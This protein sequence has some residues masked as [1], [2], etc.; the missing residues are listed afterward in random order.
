ME[1]ISQLEGYI[2]PPRT[3]MVP[4]LSLV[5]RILT[6]KKHPGL[7][8][9]KSKLYMTNEEFKNEFGKQ[10]FIIGRGTYA[11]IH[12][13]EKNF[14]I[15]EFTPDD[16]D[17]GTNFRSLTEISILKYLDH[18]NVLP[19]YG[20]NL[21]IEKCNFKF[22]MPLAQ[23]SLRDE[24]IK[25]NNTFNEYQRKLI[26]YQI[27]RGLSYCH[28][29]FIWHLDI[30]PAN[31]LK[32]SNGEYKLADF[33]IS[34]IYAF[35]GNPHE[36][37]IMS[38]PYRPPEI[39]IDDQYY[40]ETVDVWST[41]A[42]LIELITGKMFFRANTDKDMML[43]IMSLLGTPDFNNSWPEFEKLNY[44]FDLINQLPKNN[45]DTFSETL[46]DFNV[47]R[48]EMSILQQMLAWPNKRKKAIDLLNH[49]YF[50]DVRGLIDQKIPSQPIIQ[51]DCGRQMLQ[52][53]VKIKKPTSHSIGRNG[54]LMIVDWIWAVGNELKVKA[55]T[56]FF[57]YLLYDRYSS[58]VDSIPRGNEQLIILASFLLA[59]KI[60]E[61]SFSAVSDLSFLSDG[62]YTSE[63][64][65][66]MEITMLITL[67]FNIIF[68]TCADFSN[69]MMS[70]T[71][72][73]T[74][75][76]LMHNLMAV[77]M[78]NSNWAFEMD[79]REIAQSGIEI[80][81]ELYQLSE[82]ECFQQLKSGRSLSLEEI[83]EYLN[84][85]TKHDLISRV[86][87]DIKKVL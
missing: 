63:Q 58:L 27:L 25:P 80:V 73:E 86:L 1:G 10:L 44:K 6:A 55:R 84:D 35:N 15:K 34:Q 43:K 24:M 33:G 28:S 9:K 69:Y 26:I 22:A 82:T 16:C 59:S 12:L 83:V 81:S 32:F 4:T 2:N 18:P 19:I 45:A 14:A 11:A 72:P 65:I 23:E 48:N 61:D 3:I 79:Q 52:Q 66:N 30:K 17:D 47:S 87:S 85:H 29:K 68:P 13:T 76:K 8:T 67:D 39:I 40:T 38:N 51:Y 49:P 75:Q 56:L 7:F 62:A 57:T 71:T 46:K 53:Q 64:I 74:V 50:D 42:I 78:T 20:A 70:D 41:G 37:T 36:T 77:I 60:R 5:K 54:R 31:I 21:N